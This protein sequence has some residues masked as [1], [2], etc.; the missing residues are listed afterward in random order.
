M[1]G[2]DAELELMLRSSGFHMCAQH[3]RCTPN[4]PESGETGQASALLGIQ[5]PSFIPKTDTAGSC[6]ANPSLLLTK[7]M[8]TLGPS[9][10]LLKQG[11]DDAGESQ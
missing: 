7:G 5:H 6:L 11:R 1:S 10:S 4:S 8:R 2:S 9:M 3:L